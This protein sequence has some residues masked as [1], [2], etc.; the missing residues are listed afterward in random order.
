MTNTSNENQIRGRPMRLN[1]L[2]LQVS[3]VDTAREF[4]ERFS[5]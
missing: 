4:F 1:R 5:S 3:D 2:D